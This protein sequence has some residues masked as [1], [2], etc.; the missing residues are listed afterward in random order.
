MQRTG[1]SL[2]E[3]SIVLVILGLLA[4]GILAGQSLIHAAELRKTNTDLSRIQ[5]AIHTF[6]DKYF[7]LPGDMPNATQFW[8]IQMGST[9][10]DDSC[11]SSPSTSTRTCNGNGDG[12]IH[13]GYSTITH[14]ERARAWQHLANAGLIEGSYSGYQGPAGG[15]NRYGGVNALKAPFGN[16][17]YNLAYGGATSSDTRY[18]PT[19]VGNLLEMTRDF[20]V[21]EAQ[22]DILKAEDV[23]NIDTKIDDGKPAYGVLRGPKRDNPLAPGCTTS[24]E[25]SAEYALTT[26]VNNCYYWFL[27]R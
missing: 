23:W 9:G 7:A 8:Q 4:G 25:V 18:F 19:P 27:L 24:N 11:Y 22:R 3:L 21:T 16:S 17:H 15:E 12:M 2:I 13:M 1:F 26:T 14:A 20:N 6:R 5:T 10:N